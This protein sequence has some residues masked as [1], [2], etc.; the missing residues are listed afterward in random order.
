MYGNDIRDIIMMCTQNG[1]FKLNKFFFQLS[2]KKER[3]KEL[4]KF[5]ILL[6]IQF[7]GIGN[8]DKSLNMHYFVTSFV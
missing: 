3:F 2:K 1:K 6:T 7:S 4:I 8:V 5:A